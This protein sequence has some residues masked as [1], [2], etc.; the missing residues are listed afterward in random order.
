MKVKCEICKNNFEAGEVNG[1]TLPTYEGQLYL[2][3]Y[4]KIIVNKNYFVCK[5]CQGA[6]IGFIEALKEEETNE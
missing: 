6:I 3:K 4:K 5:T 2:G 1:M